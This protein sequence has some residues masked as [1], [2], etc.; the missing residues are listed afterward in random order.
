LGFAIVELNGEAE[1]EEDEDK[2]E[3]DRFLAVAVK[4]ELF[5]AL[6]FDALPFRGRLRI[7]LSI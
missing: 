1:N 4:E 5:K 6:F 7:N 3:L 2:E